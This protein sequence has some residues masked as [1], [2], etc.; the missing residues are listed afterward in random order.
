MEARSCLFAL[1]FG[2]SMTRPILN[3][4]SCLSKILKC[5]VVGLGMLLIL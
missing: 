2:S 4:Y 3:I 1:D 5:L